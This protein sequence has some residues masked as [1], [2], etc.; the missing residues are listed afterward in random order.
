MTHPGRNLPHGELLSR[1]SATSHM[2]LRGLSAGIGELP[3]TTSLHTP[4]STLCTMVR[5]EWNRSAR[6]LDKVLAIKVYCISHAN[7][8][9]NEPE[10]PNMQI[11]GKSLVLDE[12][13]FRVW[14]GL[15]D[16][17]CCISESILDLDV[18]FWERRLIGPPPPI[19]RLFS[20]L[21]Y[22]VDRISFLLDATGE[23]EHS[24]SDPFTLC[25]SIPFTRKKSGN[26]IEH[27][28]SP[29]ANKI[30]SSLELA[31]N[32]AKAKEWLAGWV[33]HAHIALAA[34]EAARQMP[35]IN[36]IVDDLLRR[37]LLSTSIA[38]LDRHSRK[39]S[40]PSLNQIAVTAL[41]SPP[42]Q[43][44]TVIAMIYSPCPLSSATSGFFNGILPHFS[45]FSDLPD[46]W[47]M[48]MSSPFER[49]SNG[50]SENST[51]PAVGILVQTAE[52]G[53][54]LDAG[55]FCVTHNGKSVFR[56]TNQ[57]TPTMW[58]LITILD[59]HRPNVVSRK[60]IF[61]ALTGREINERAKSQKNLVERHVSNLRRKLSS[62]FGF[63]SHDW[64][65]EQ[66]DGYALIVP[67]G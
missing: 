11:T 32:R 38:V 20:M 22:S 1:I 26:S 47:A 9:S 63:P 54:S 16:F 36:S 18:N 17:D 3:S 48:S 56:A 53:W 5:Q 64:I 24:I 12:K 59:R 45:R 6:E 15:S 44:S 39:A 43:S 4:L 14:V 21:Q 34:N 23:S 52:V 67:I 2:L 62:V 40:P 65:P 35:N 46:Q 30:K 10:L 33:D 58:K 42:R 25:I 31:M 41:I 55:Q 50:H 66:G 57:L 29:C 28:L 37:Q 27:P 7:G 49:Q 8:S 13:S 51:K 60:R 61:H 19:H